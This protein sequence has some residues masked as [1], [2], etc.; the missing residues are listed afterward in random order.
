M[1]KRGVKIGVARGSEL[2]DP[3]SLLQG[4]GKVHRH[5]P[6]HEI[7]DLKHPGLKTILE[8]GVDAWRKRTESTRSPKRQLK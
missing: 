7:G 8:T 2:P 4:S 3:N 5:V 6:L 1:S